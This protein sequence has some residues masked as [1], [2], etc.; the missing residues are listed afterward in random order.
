RSGIRII[1]GRIVRARI[2]WQS[3][4]IV[5]GLP[6]LLCAVAVA[7]MA[8]LGQRALWPSPTAWRELPERFVFIFLFIGLGEEPGWR[9]FA[10]PELQRKHSPLSACLILAPVWAILHLPLVGNEF[11]L[12][13]VTAFLLSPFGATFVL[14]W[15]FN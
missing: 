1:L 10:L 8:A 12:P 2:G 6:V 15:I 11:S 13:I 7:V 5:F 3:Y 4:A 9:G 14:P